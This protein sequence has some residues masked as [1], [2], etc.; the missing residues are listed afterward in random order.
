M[1][2]NILKMKYSKI[3]LLSVVVLVLIL[4]F[5]ALK[6]KPET[7]D[8][9]L[10]TFGVTYPYRTSLIDDKL[11]SFDGV[12]FLST[13]IKTGEGEVISTGLKLPTPSYIAW[14][15]GGVLLNFEEDYLGSAIQ[16]ELR[17]N[18]IS[19][20]SSSNA[21][22][23]LNFKTGKISFVGHYKILN[24]LAFYSSSDKSIY[25]IPDSTQTDS[26]SKQL[27]KIDESSGKVSGVTTIELDSIISLTPCGGVEDSS[28]CVVGQVGNSG[29]QQL[30]FLNKSQSFE[31]ISEPFTR[32]FPTN[33]NN[34]FVFENGDINDSNYSFVDK[35]GGNV[36]LFDLVDKS[37]ISLGFETSESEPIF[38]FDNEVKTDDTMVY[39]AVLNSEAETNQ[40]QLYRSGV[41]KN[42]KT[43]TAV[44]PLLNN[45]VDNT[46]FISSKVSYSENF[47]VSVS[48]DG[49]LLVFANSVIKP[50]LS[51]VEKEEITTFADVC[52]KKVGGQQNYLD[53]SRILNVYIPY[54]S[55]FEMNVDGFAK[56]LSSQYSSIS[57]T[58]ID[59]FGTQNNRVVTD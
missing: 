51:V 34:L 21:T 16:S 2:Q 45:A 6:P 33:R 44:K 18:N 4:M 32:V 27:L 47:I 13:D 19:V 48:F 40:H 10:Q 1:I 39:F 28:V 8:F 14:S 7:K 37:I 42:D 56:C 23:F 25:F 5:F 35:S 54:S 24:N 59:I 50:N 52:V 31:A 57:D 43:Y 55:N 46:K 15:K 20:S 41:I 29:G 36:L 12:R 9:Q 26:L 17:A 11:Y 22:W 38:F 3:A 30:F 53:S 58:I 49:S